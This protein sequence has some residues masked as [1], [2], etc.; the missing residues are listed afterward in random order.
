VFWN[1]IVG[2]L[3]SKIKN[4]KS[5]NTFGFGTKKNLVEIAKVESS[6]EE[7][8]REFWANWV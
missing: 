8:L 1:I 3:K 6:R 7:G 2:I 5:L 4:R